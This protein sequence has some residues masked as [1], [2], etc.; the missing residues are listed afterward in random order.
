MQLHR[1]AF[2]TGLLAASIMPV[3]PLRFT[4]GE[5]DEARMAF[6]VG[7]MRAMRPHPHMVYVSRTF[8]DAYEA[9]LRRKTGK[10]LVERIG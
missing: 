8:M 7:A 4:A 10:P 3:K 2:L 9:E 6:L 5:I 1:R